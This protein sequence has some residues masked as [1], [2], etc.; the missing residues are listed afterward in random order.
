MGQ[1]SLVDSDGDT[2]GLGRHLDGGVDDAAVVPLP[3]TGGEDKQAVAYGIHGF[4]VFHGV[5]P[6][7]PGRL[8]SFQYVP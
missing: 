5:P 6:W 1:I 4:F 7:R 8:F 2:V 3:L